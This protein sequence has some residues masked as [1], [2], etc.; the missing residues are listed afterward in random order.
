MSGSIPGGVAIHQETDGARRREHGYLCVAI[1]V[2][3]SNVYRFV[4][5]VCGFLFQMR[6]FL[7][8]RDLV[9]CAAMQ[10]D[11]F[12]HRSDIILR[13]RLRHAAGT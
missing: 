2:T 13:N 12:Q 7:C 6:E 10:F 4:P 9:H 1:P 8:V 11:H 5:S 3:L